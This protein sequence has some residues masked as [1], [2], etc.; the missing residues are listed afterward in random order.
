MEM[1]LKIKHTVMMVGETKADLVRKIGRDHL[2]SYS[3]YGNCLTPY[4]KFKQDTVRVYS[5][6]K[7]RRKVE[8]TIERFKNGNIKKR[9]TEVIHYSQWIGYCYDIPVEV[10]KIG[11]LKVV[12]ESRTWKLVPR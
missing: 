2:P 12:Q 9:S 5:M 3:S 10:L 7:R 8:R 11:K 1:R 6:E 4:P